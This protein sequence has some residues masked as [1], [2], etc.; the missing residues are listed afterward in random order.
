M[1]KNLHM[2]KQ[3]RRSAI[4]NFTADQRICF[5]YIDST[6]HL[7]FKLNFQ[8]SSFL[9]YM[10]SSLCVVPGRNPNC[11]FSNVKAHLLTLR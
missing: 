9:V 4:S 5:H 10:Y 2:R 1:K 6:K 8:I 3:R 7:L 11:W